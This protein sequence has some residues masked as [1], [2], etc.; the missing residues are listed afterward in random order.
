MKAEAFLTVPGVTGDA[1]AELETAITQSIDKVT[2]L[3]PQYAPGASIAGVPT[4]TNQANRTADYI[5]FVLNRFAI[6]SDADKLQII[7]KEFYIAAWGNGIEPYNNYRRT[8][9]PDNFQPTLEENPGPYFY[10]ALYAGASVNNNPNAPSNV[11]TKKV[12]WDKANL[13]LH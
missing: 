13:E 11:R 12:F 2:H 5:E 1:S 4:P 6:S 9:Y 3:L 10:T 7:I 8:G